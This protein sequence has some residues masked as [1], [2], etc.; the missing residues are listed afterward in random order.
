MYNF[1]PEKIYNILKDDPIYIKWDTY[2]NQQKNSVN[3]N[4]RK[5]LTADYEVEQTDEYKNFIKEISNLIDTKCPQYKNQFIILYF[6]FIKKDLLSLYNNTKFDMETTLILLAQL[7][8][9]SYVDRDYQT[10]IN[11]YTTTY[12]TI[13]TEERS[14]YEEYCH[15]R[16]FLSAPEKYMLTQEKNLSFLPTMV[17][18][19]KNLRT[20]M[21][22]LI[23]SDTLNHCYLQAVDHMIVN[24][25]YYVDNDEIIAQNITDIDFEEDTIE[26]QYKEYSMS[27]AS[28]KDKKF[29][30]YFANK[31]YIKAFVNMKWLFNYI[32]KALENPSTFFK[33]LEYYN[34]INNYPMAAIIRRMLKVQQLFPDLGFSLPNLEEED[35]TLLLRDDLKDIT[36]PSHVASVTFGNFVR[37]I[38]SWIDTVGYNIDRINATYNMQELKQEVDKMYTEKFGS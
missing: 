16:Y 17:N 31:E 7:I 25:S 35:K 37:H 33:G 1:F 28:I 30:V 32:N 19:I 12:E 29:E 26:T 4:F 9:T 27:R 24:A 8:N 15:I 11:L 38:D 2:V 34:K 6:D 22:S 10:Y 13:P 36:T 14:N 21:S 3:I 20:E 23:N 18:Y 5:S